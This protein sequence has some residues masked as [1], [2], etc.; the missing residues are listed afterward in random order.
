MYKTSNDN[1]ITIKTDS[2]VSEY[3]EDG[4]W[5]VL[6]N[7]S[8][9]GVITSD[10]GFNGNTDVTEVKLNNRVNVIGERA[11]YGCSKLRII[12]APSVTLVQASAFNY[13]LSECNMPNLKEIEDYGIGEIS[14][15]DFPLLETIGSNVFSGFGGTTVNLPSLKE[16][17][18]SAFSGSSLKTINLPVVETI[19]SR[20]FSACSNLSSVDLPSIKR[21]GDNAFANIANNAVM[22]LGENL[23]RVYLTCFG[24][25]TREVYCYGKNS[26]DLWSSVPPTEAWRQKTYLTLH[27]YPDATGYNKW[28]TAWGT[29]YAS[30]LSIL[31]DLQ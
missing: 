7:E 18:I 13:K 26:P 25:G 22:R 19:E 9:N 2:L 8:F 27:V 11:F 1:A 20:A 17:G 14:T 31:Y 24:Q 5:N 16:I 30:H 15:I 12:D 29:S 23:E 21:I 28:T 3:F 4:Y 10:F 6:L